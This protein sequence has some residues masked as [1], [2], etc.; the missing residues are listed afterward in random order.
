MHGWLMLVERGSSGDS[1]RDSDARDAKVG[2]P[3]T[4]GTGRA[5]KGFVLWRAG[6]LARG[7]RGAFLHTGREAV[8]RPD[9]AAQRRGTAM[10]IS[11]AVKKVGWQ[12]ARE[13]AMSGGNAPRE[14]CDDRSDR[15][16][17]SAVESGTTS[18]GSTGHQRVFE[19]RGRE[20]NSIGRDGRRRLERIAGAIVACDR[21]RPPERVEFHRDH[22]LAQTTRRQGTWSW[23]VVT[24]GTDSTLRAGPGWDPATGL[25][26]PDGWNFVQAFGEGH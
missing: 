21:Y 6:S 12:S 1:R 3:K 15:F 5:V 23:F 18:V 25:G 19:H 8:K 2:G 7:Q 10:Q 16:R 13:R 11:T 17:C 26:T 20:Y 9:T 14:R 4:Q 24:F 22:C